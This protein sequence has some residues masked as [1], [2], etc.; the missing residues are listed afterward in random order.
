M[1]QTKFLTEHTGSGTWNS[2]L[3]YACSCAHVYWWQPEGQASSGHPARGDSLSVFWNSLMPVTPRNP[4]R[5]PS[6]TLKEFCN[7]KVILYTRIH[8][9]MYSFLYI[10]Y[11]IRIFNC[12]CN[13]AYFDYW[14]I[15]VMPYEL[16]LRFVL[17]RTL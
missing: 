12:F 9:N 8:E 11:L 2:L 14:M 6:P 7:K 16:F 15:R 1:T 10:F 17:I 13:V 5:F 4:P 3:L